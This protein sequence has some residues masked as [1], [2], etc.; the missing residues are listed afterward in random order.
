MAGTKVKEL[1][2][3]GAAV[4]RELASIVVDATTYLKMQ[5]IKL[6]D[7]TFCIDMR[8][9][10][11]KDGFKRYGVR[12]PVAI[13]PDVQ[14]ELGE[15]YKKFGIKRSYKTKPAKAKAEAAAVQRCVEDNEIIARES[16]RAAKER[17]S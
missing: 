2:N 14:F 12:F 11:V 10:T 9:W 5:V 17:V 8:P 4:V 3:N 6:E 15:A 7:G 16:R 13:V 1:G